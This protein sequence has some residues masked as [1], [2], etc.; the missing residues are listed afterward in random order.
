MRALAFVDGEQ[1]RVQSYN[2]RDV[3][4][5]WPEL[6]GLPDALPGDDRAARRRAGGHR[7]RGPPELRAPPAADARHRAR[8]GGRPRRR[9]AGGLRGVRPAPP[10]RPRPLRPAA[11]RSTAAPRPG[12]RAGSAVAGVAAARRRPRPARGRARHAG[13]RASWP[14]AST[15]ATSRASAPGRWLKVKV[16]LRQE[17]VVG[18]WLPGEGNRTGRIG[19]LLVGYHDAPGDGGPLRFA[20]RVGTGFKDA[21]LTRLGRLFDELATDECPFDP[22][23]PRAEIL[24]GPALGATRAGGRARVRRV[25]PRRPPAP[26]ELPRPARRQAGRRGDPR[27]LT[28]TRSASPSRP[29][30][31]WRRWWS[32]ARRARS[33]RQVALPRRRRSTELRAAAAVEAFAAQADGDAATS[34]LARP[35]ARERRP[36]RAAPIEVGADVPAEVGCV[37][38][39]WSRSR[40]RGCR[41]RA[42]RP[43]TTRTCATACTT[44]WAMRSPRRTVYGSVGIEV[45]Q[46]HL[47]LVAVAAVD[48]PRR[49]EAG[50]PVAQGQPAARL[51]EPGVALGQGEGDAGGH[52]RPPA[53]GRQRGVLAGQQVEA[54][55]ARPRRRRAAAGRDR[56]APRGRRGRSA[57]SRSVGGC[58]TPTGRVRRCWCGWTSR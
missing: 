34:I 39:R 18:G 46:Q 20:G 38:A 49:V 11:G 1:L 56:G 43:P 24:R 22:P 29:T 31:T 37:S 17:M 51:H 21:E 47:Q 57:R 19:A 26:P 23:P 7:R 2:E 8:R 54:G 48:E 36:V 53:A 6:A 9:G 27:C 42:R 52:Q 41:R 44:S 40:R 32:S 35:A 15:P 30:P 16:R 50:D 25:D 10:R 33:A 5:S 55:V 12:A 3:T 4:V 13:S 58:R 45:D 14:S 28:T